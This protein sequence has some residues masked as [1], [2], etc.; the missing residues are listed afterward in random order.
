MTCSF[1]S[2]QRPET[3]RVLCFEILPQVGSP[4]WS[5]TTFEVKIVTR[6]DPCKNHSSALPR[7][8]PKDRRP[9]P[10]P[11]GPRLMQKTSNQQPGPLT[12]EEFLQAEFYFGRRNPTR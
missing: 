8:V 1:T 10:P 11:Q 4:A 6:T 5:S 7:R 2:S 3:T 12:S 9:R